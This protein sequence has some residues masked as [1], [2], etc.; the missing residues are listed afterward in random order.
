MKA[1]NLA[2]Q[3][4]FITNKSFKTLMEAVQGQKI[5]VSVN[6]KSTKIGSFQMFIPDSNHK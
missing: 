4:T 1:L 3:L 2:K 5:H 6:E